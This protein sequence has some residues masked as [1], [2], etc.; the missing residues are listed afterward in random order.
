MKLTRAVL[1]G[2]MERRRGGIINVASMSGFLMMPGNVS[3][4]A[5][6]TWMITF[7]EGVDLELRSAGSP[8]RMQA[9]CPGYTYSE[10]H[11][12]LGVNRKSIP[13][14]MW[15]GSEYVVA[16]SLRGFDRG[17]LLVIPGWPYRL[18]ARLLALLP[19][20]VHRAV[21]RSYGERHRKAHRAPAGVRPPGSS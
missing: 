11:D 5:T 19:K 7:T 10:F 3:Y 21:A 9:L 8:V 4:C 20:S 15:R 18:G 6:K 17:R 13:A 16:E 2:L 14:W 12:V 1:P